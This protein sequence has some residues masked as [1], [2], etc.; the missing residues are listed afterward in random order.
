MAEWC[1]PSLLRLVS[2][3]NFV[4]LLRA[5]VLE[6]KIVVL[7]QN[8]GILANVVYDIALGISRRKVQSLN[9][10]LSGSGCP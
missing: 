4:L 5:L 3:D 2:L 8:L 9:V 7:C 6:F 10:H 1:L